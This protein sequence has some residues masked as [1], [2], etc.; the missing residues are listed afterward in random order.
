MSK[1]NPVTFFEN[2]ITVYILKIFA[3]IFGIVISVK[4]LSI[5]PVNR[6]LLVTTCYAARE[7]F[8]RTILCD[9]LAAVYQALFFYVHMICH[10]LIL[11]MPLLRYSVDPTK[12]HHDTQCYV[13][14]S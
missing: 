13:F 3:S 8:I 4:K 9:V 10:T 5:S 6:S 7:D 12:N 1:I 2:S 14:I 11:R